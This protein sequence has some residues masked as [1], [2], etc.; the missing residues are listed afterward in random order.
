MLRPFSTLHTR[1]PSHK[2]R[3]QHVTFAVAGAASVSR[4]SAIVYSPHALP[5]ISSD[6]IALENL[7]ILYMPPERPR[8]RAPARPHGSCSIRQLALPRGPVLGFWARYAPER[9]DSSAA[10]LRAHSEAPFARATHA[11]A[12]RNLV[13][14]GRSVR[15]SACSSVRCAYCALYSVP[16]SRF[17]PLACLLR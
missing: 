7:A 4:R 17:C 9:Y 10:A 3:L 6:R 14:P 15:R 1:A 12:T 11:G 13:R 16:F 8:A 5:S 2:P